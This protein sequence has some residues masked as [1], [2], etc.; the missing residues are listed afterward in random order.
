MHLSCELAITSEIEACLMPFNRFE[1]PEQAAS[2]MAHLHDIGVECEY[3]K[4][5][6]E[7]ET[8]MLELIINNLRRT[9]RR[10]TKRLKTVTLRIFTYK[11][12]A[13]MIP[14]W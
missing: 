8:S 3:G 9:S 5:H 12:S 1:R 13:R 4:V 6:Q 10:S 14:T 2:F 7:S 11:V